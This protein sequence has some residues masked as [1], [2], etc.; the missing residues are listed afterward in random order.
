MQKQPD[1]SEQEVAFQ[2]SWLAVYEKQGT[3]WVQKVSASTFNSV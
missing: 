1:E 2:C 3:E